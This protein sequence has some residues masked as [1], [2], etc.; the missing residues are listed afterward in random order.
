LGRWFNRQPWAQSFPFGTLV[1]NASGSFLLGIFAVVLL[2][3]AEPKQTDW[4]L[5]LGTGFCV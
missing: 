1:I 4:Y 2:E 5:L 3:R